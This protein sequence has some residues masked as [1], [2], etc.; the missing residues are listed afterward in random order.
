MLFKGVSFWE[1]A[2]ED[3]V[4]W[5][6]NYYPLTASGE[7]WRLLTHLF[8][9]IGVVHLAMNLYALYFIGTYLEPLAGRWRM[10]LLFVLTGLVA[11]VVSIWWSDN[12]VSAGASGG[13]FG[14]IGVLLALLVTG[15]AGKEMRAALLTNLC[16]YAGINLVMGLQENID[17]AAHSGGLVSG[18]LLGLLVAGEHR[19]PS[20]TR[21]LRTGGVALPLLLITGFLLRYPFVKP[22]SYY[23]VMQEVAI[24][25]RDASWPFSN[26][27]DKSKQQM[28]GEMER[29]SIPK[30]TEATTLMQ[31]VNPA[32]IDSPFR[33]MHVLLQ[34]YMHMRLREAAFYIQRA[35][36]SVHFSPAAL[37]TLQDSIRV[38]NDALLQFAGQ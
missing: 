5:G 10:L 34:D 16:I 23:A 19:W 12:R 2:V 33:K 31:G 4:T 20:V 13:L 37:Q 27:D 8:V 14:L 21:W 1:P 28:A 6:G 3:L 17:N 38:Q 36:D 9:H 26:I 29:V 11:G 7:Y 35:D 24:L 32:Q 25:D 18:F 15:T 22:F 30:W